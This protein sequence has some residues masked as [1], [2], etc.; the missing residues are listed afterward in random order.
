MEPA[1]G[2]KKPVPEWLNSSLWSSPQSTSSVERRPSPATATRSPVA[3]IPKS[4]SPQNPSSHC[5][6]SVPSESKPVGDDICR[7]SGKDVTVSE[8]SQQVEE[9]EHKINISDDPKKLPYSENT[10]VLEDT[11]RF[12]PQPRGG[13]ADNEE[14]HQRNAIDEEDIDLLSKKARIPSLFPSSSF[15]ANTY[16]VTRSS[17]FDSRVNQ[18]NSELSKKVI[19]LA[20]LQRLASQ[21][22]PDCGSIRAITWKLLLR[23]LPKNRDN[24][25]IELEKKRAEYSSFKEE[26]LVTP[27]EITRRKEDSALD[28]SARDCQGPLPRHDI[29]QEDHP[30]S[31]G[32]SSIWHQYFLD[33]EV[34]EQIDRDVK[35]THP[36]MH[37][38]CGDSAASLDNQEAMKRVLFIFS[39]LNPGIRYVQGMN[40]VLAPL[41]YVF[42][43]D[44]DETNAE[45]VIP[46]QSSCTGLDSGIMACLSCL[47]AVG[48]R[49]TIGRLNEL[50]K[51]Q[52]EEL[53]RH[54]EYTNKVNTQFYAFR[55]ITLLLTQEFSF[56]DSLRLWDSLLGNPEGPLE[57]LLRL[58]CA[59]LMSVKSRLLAGDFASNLKLLQHYPP[60]DVHHLIRV[61]DELKAKSY[62][63]G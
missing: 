27:S 59:M 51:K 28:I 11:S 23:Y 21:G 8:N 1:G 50:L 46:G 4:P 41:F 54:L 48:I 45:R 16:T 44:T 61:A 35:R 2:S 24:W 37:F 34:C 17:S 13:T 18:F 25:S 58:C 52:D 62:L 57:I 56:P 40:E 7:P 33:S 63:F 47:S 9:A 30:L 55:W 31:L 3:S 39:K 20:E 19:S 36:D 22:I 53:W 49:S 6:D 12:D 32:K 43:T 15:P 14:N 38:F 10:D 42:K 60:T 29:T 5:R 26:L